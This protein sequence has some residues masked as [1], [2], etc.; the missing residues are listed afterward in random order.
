MKT[1]I[2][3]TALIAHYNETLNNNDMGSTE[4]TA[5]IKER[6]GS[7]TVWIRFWAGKEQLLWDVDGDRFVV[8]QPEEDSEIAELY[9]RIEAMR[10]HNAMRDDWER[11]YDDQ[12]FAEVYSEI[13]YLRDSKR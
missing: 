13:E 10:E 3:R 1:A 4:I 9:E 6:N 12:D 11:E 8:E 7:Y 5:V 2:D